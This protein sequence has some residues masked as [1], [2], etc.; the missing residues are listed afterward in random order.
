VGVG[1]VKGARALVRDSAPRTAPP[2]TY[3]RSGMAGLLKAGHGI[4]T[5]AARAA[6]PCPGRSL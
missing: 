4:G 1:G 3:R 2:L 5:L 6:P